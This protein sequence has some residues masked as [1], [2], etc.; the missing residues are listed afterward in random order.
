MTNA[1][2]STKERIKSVAGSAKDTPKGTRLDLTLY[3]YPDG[4]SNIHAD[5]A[6]GLVQDDPLELMQTLAT[7]LRQVRFPD[8][9][10][11]GG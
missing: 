6:A 3:L 9:T 11:Y 7:L 1:K 10:R 2:T 5:G 4:R 8:G